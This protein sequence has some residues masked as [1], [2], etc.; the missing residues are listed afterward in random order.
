MW[1]GLP[2]PVQV[3]W[4]QARL[5]VEEVV[6]GPGDAA[7]QLRER[8]D[9]RHYRLDIRQ[10]PL[11]RAFISHDQAQDRWLLLLLSHHLTIDHTTL[12]VIF[13]DVQ[14]HLLGESQHLSAPV[15]FRN[16]VAQARG[17]AA[18]S[19]EEHEQFFRQMLGDIEG[20]DSAIWVAGCARG[21]GR[22]Q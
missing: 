10:A 9:P 19:A 11:Q 4:R 20:V 6:L 14:A 18:I 16:F 17:P 7:A 12:E 21:W 1:Q 8:L 13:G 2:Q 5:S 3:V 22:D 15:P